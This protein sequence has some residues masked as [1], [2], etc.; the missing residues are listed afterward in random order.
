MI[1]IKL[2]VIIILILILVLI[3]T[4]KKQEKIINYNLS[5]NK[6]IWNKLGTYWP[7][8]PVMRSQGVVEHNLWAKGGCLDKYD[9]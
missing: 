8:V 2:L 3:T 1:I 5:S 9:T 6:P 7:M 4:R